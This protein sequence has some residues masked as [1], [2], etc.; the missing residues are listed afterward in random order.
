MTEIDKKKLQ[1]LINVPWIKKSGVDITD[2]KYIGPGI[3]MLLHQKGSKANTKEK[4]KEFIQFVKDVY[5]NFPCNFC[6]GHFK[7]YI[8]EHPLEKYLNV[9]LVGENGKKIMIGMFLWSWKFHNAV[10]HRLQKP[11]MN[12]D[13]AYE[14]YYVLPTTEKK[15]CSKECTEAAGEG[16]PKQK[17]KEHQSLV[18]VYKKGK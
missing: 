15:I 5:E 10:N 7:V 18:N 16:S 2:P 1:N 4:Q 9:Y 11:M 12:W 3:W 6:R 8:Q 14:M 13:T 17:D